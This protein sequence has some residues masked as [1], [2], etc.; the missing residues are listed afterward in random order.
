MVAFLLG[1][2]IPGC[3]TGVFVNRENCSEAFY[4]LFYRTWVSS[5]FGVCHD[6]EDLGWSNEDHQ[7][8]D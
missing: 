7:I 4:W 1:V 8:R 2:C 5:E 3:G 6:L